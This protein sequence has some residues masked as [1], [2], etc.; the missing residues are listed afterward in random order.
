MNR[1]LESFE[2]ITKFKT[3]GVFTSGGDSPGMNS[4]VR[5]VAR[6]CAFHGVQCI[7]IEQGYRGMIENKM[8]PLG[9]RDV[10]NIVHRGGTFLR[11]AR[12][13][14]FMEKSGRKQAFENLKKHGVEALVCIGGDGSFT[15]ANI[16]EQEFGIPTLGIPGTIDNDIFGTDFTLGYDTALNTVVEAVDKIR[17]TA[18]SH[19]RIFFVEVMGRDAG[20]IALNAGIA[21][22]ATQIL[23]PETQD[24]FEDVFSALETA[25][26]NGK[27][28]SIVL[29]SEKDEL[30]S[31]FDIA[32]EAKNH[33]PDYDIRVT[34]LGHIQ[35]GGAPSC[36][37][38]VLGA[39]FGVAAVEG[40]LQ[41][42]KN[43]MVGVKGQDISYTDFD[44]AVKQHNPLDN[45]MVRVAKILAGT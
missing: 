37:D 13:K 1:S 10:S 32:K 34:V 43:Q 9:P 39:R 29:V 16:F 21:S 44:K 7:G 22:G 5:A 14:E 35:R 42:R 24:T 25:R 41:G 18:T 19:D 30:G 2:N 40:L 36:L 15:G 27:T 31:V 38:R 28:S 4:A 3:I 12:C 6:T 26:K 45:S 20:F 11:T 8:I 33:F 17:D 23:I